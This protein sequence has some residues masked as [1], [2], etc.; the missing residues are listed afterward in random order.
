MSFGDKLRR[1]MRLARQSVRLL[2]GSPGLL[3][4]PI[5]SGAVLLLIIAAFAAPIIAN[6]ELRSLLDGDGADT[7]IA[8]YALTFAFYLVAFTAM[9]IFNTALVHAILSRLDGG[10]ASAAQGL[11][12]AMTRLPQIF[13]WSLLSAT[14]GVALRV[15]QDKAGALGGIVGGL[16]G[17]AWSVATYFA[18]PVLAAQGTGPL[19]TVSR[20][21]AILRKTWGESL[22]ANIGVGIIM[23][24]PVLI[25]ILAFAVAAVTLPAA[26]LIGVGVVIGAL[27][28]LV[29]LVS[30]TLSVTVRTALYHYAVTDST[31]PQFDKA[32]FEQAFV[33][34]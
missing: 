32:D 31:P 27:F 23:V 2:A 14:V 22:A 30:S 9:N 3:V 15:M 34:K 19:E 1:A 24:V 11:R 4:L 7:E 16:A 10:T 17:L 18:V 6:P 12:F 25:L 29:L 8:D 21:A 26:A 33:K 28:A 13:M 5:A 20:S